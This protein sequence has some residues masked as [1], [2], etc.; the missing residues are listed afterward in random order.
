MVPSA[1]VDPSPAKATA[2]QPAHP[3]GHR[4]L[5]FEL[6][7]DDNKLPQLFTIKLNA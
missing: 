1:G 4:I 6:S 3:N 2:D 5:S 7:N